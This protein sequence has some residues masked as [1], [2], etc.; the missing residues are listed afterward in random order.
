MQETWHTKHR[1]IAKFSVLLSVNPPKD[2]TWEPSAVPSIIF[3]ISNENVH[4]FSLWYSLPYDHL[5]QVYLH[6]YV[7]LCGRLKWGEK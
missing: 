1:S 7:V 2:K 5:G 4:A 3:F 6:L